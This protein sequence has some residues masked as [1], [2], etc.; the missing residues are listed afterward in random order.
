MIKWKLIDKET[1]KRNK[2]IVKYVM[3]FE[4]D[5]EK[6]FGYIT[7]EEDD[8]EEDDFNGYDYL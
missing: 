3:V 2:Q 5:P 7:E 8:D 1:K 4:L 6:K